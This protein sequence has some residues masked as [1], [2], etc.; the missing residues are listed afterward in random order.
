MQIS[1]RA[2]LIGAPAHLLAPPALAHHSLTM[3]DP[4]KRVTLVGTVRAFNW[5]NPHIEIRL[6]VQDAAGR[7]VEW[8]VEASNPGS[9]SRR[10]WSSQSMKAGDHAQIVVHPMRNGTP[11]GAMITATVNGVLVGARG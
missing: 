8:I 2:L 6:A 9:L 5:A 1:K 10:G 11:V 7:E 4:A 3:F